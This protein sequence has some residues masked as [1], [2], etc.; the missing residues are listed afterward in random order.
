MQIL[1]QANSPNPENAEALTLGIKVANKTKSP[2]VFASDPDCDRIGVAVLE[3]RG[4]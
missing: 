4:K 2:Y 1:V 3:D